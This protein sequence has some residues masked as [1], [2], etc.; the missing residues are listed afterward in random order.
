MPFAFVLF[1]GSFLSLPSTQEKVVYGADDRVEYFDATSSIQDLTRRSIVALMTSNTVGTASGDEY[2]GPSASETLQDAFSLCDGEAFLTQPTAAFCSGTLIGPDLVLTAGHCVT[3]VSQC[4]STR[5]VF[6]FFYESDGQLRTI[7]DESVY[8]CI[9][10]VSVLTSTIDYAIVKLDRNV[11]GDRSPVEVVSQAVAVDENVVL[12][13]IGFPSG[14]PAK[15]LAQFSISDNRESEMDFFVG[16]PDTFGGNSGSGVFDSDS[17]VVGILVRGA[18]DYSYSSADSCYTVHDCATVGGAECGGESM[19]Y[20]FH[21]AEM[22]QSMECSSDG[23]CEDSKTCSDGYCW[24]LERCGQSDDFEFQDIRMV[25]SETTDSTVSGRVEVLVN[26]QW[27]TICDDSVND[28]VVDVLCRQLGY[29]GGNEFHNDAGT[30]PIWMDGLSCDGSEDS[31]AECDHTDWGVHDCS[32][33]EDVAVTCSFSGNTDD[34]FQIRLAESETTSEGNIA[35]RV[36]VQWFGVWGTVC[37]DM[38]T[39]ETADVIC[40]E[41]GYS[42]AAEDGYYTAGGGDGEIWLDSLSC[43]GSE[44]SVVDCDHDQW[45]SNNCYHNE[46]VGVICSISGTSGGSLRLSDV[47][48]DSGSVRGRV[49]IRHFGAWGTICDDDFTFEN[50]NVLCKQLGYDEATDDGFYAAGG[51]SGQILL[52]QVSCDGTERY[53]S[54]CQHN[55]WGDHNCVHTEDVGVIC[56][57][58][59]DP[60]SVRLR[61]ISSGSADS[62]TVA[63]RVEVQ[64]AGV[65]GTICDDNFGMNEAQV[66]CRELGYA[67]AIDSYTA[68]MGTNTNLIWLDQVSCDG[69]ESSISE[70]QH[71]SWGTSDCDHGEDVGVICVEASTSSISD[72]R[73]VPVR[74]G[75]D[76]SGRVEVQINGVW[77]TICNND[78]TA[79]DADTVCRTVGYP[80]GSIG[81]GYFTAGGGD[82]SSPIWF[83]SIDCSSSDAELSDCDVVVGSSCTHDDDVGVNCVTGGASQ[84]GILSVVAILLISLWF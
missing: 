15:I 1:V 24:N 19:T 4:C 18:R 45:G 52:D 72:V 59:G 22:L 9:D 26:D 34:S 41:L 35:G 78:F 31:I 66:V 51:G 38:F 12:D 68:G 55:E 21:A 36:E 76:G 37:D 49:E 6:D 10:Y 17:K 83:D 47:T 28:N 69:S 84:L 3:S 77:G 48:V 58:S 40:R 82:E 11:E 32:H 42:E 16:E 56:S 33:A 2:S 63:G 64:R 8:S 71:D 54:D 25:V 57:Y 60:D 50:A 29:A 61:L 44:S 73:L 81:K 62:G 27:G 39:F 23:D 53:I 75:G 80:A 70:C 46:D 20:A 65:W 13:M 30:G 5:L 79:N 43:E 14:L 7:T 67:D 74:N